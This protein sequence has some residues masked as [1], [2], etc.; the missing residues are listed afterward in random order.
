MKARSRNVKGHS[1]IC[2]LWLVFFLFCNLR[3]WCWAKNLFSLWFSIL[4]AGEKKNVWLGF[5]VISEGGQSVGSRALQM[6]P[7]IF[8][9]PSMSAPWKEHLKSSWVFS[10][11]IQKLF[12]RYGVQRVCLGPKLWSIRHILNGAGEVRLSWNPQTQQ[13][14]GDACTES[15][16][17]SMMRA[18]AC[19]TILQF[20]SVIPLS[21]S[22]SFA[23]SFLFGSPPILFQRGSRE[24]QKSGEDGWLLCLMQIVKTK[25]LEFPPQ[26]SGNK[27][28]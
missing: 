22:D 1:C 19:T 23:M 11:D 16:Y 4:I 27:P 6:R 8:N 14:R 20:W 13:I 3:V 15:V 21:S 18:Y 25:T 24:Q 5:M 9:S 17:I 26:L 10:T 2:H 12:N 28:D 7:E